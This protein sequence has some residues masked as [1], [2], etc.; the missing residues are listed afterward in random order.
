[1]VVKLLG[2]EMTRPLINRLTEIR[3]DNFS[4]ANENMKKHVKR[5]TEA[6][7]KKH[8]VRNFDL[9][10]HDK[11][12]VLIQKDANRKGGKM[13]SKVKPLNG[14]YVISKVLQTKKVCILENPST[15][16][17]LKKKYPFDHIVPWK[18][19]RK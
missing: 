15:K 18:V 7:N 5:Y 9:K 19:K 4:I 17:V 14:F 12:Q 1:M 2:A 16:Q 10:R 3:D 11:V 8:Q 6:Y 13:R